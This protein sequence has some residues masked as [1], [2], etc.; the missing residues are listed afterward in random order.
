M[1]KFGLHPK[2]VKPSRSLQLERNSLVTR[3]APS[4]HLLGG[5]LDYPQLCA[6]CSGFR[7]EPHPPGALGAPSHREIATDRTR[8]GGDGVERRG[9][10]SLKDFIL[11]WLIFRKVDV[12]FFPSGF[13]YWGCE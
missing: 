2:D 5:H 6:G 9:A 4:Q 12:C 1:V 11:R 7:G 8:Q 3:V 13:I 10:W